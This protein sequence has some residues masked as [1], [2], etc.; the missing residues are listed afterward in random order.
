MDTDRLLPQPAGPATRSVAEPHRRILVLAGVMFAAL[1]AYANTLNADFVWDDRKL[2]VDD[3]AITSWRHI[4][5]IFANDFFFRN[6]DDVPYGYYRPVTTLSYLLDYSIWGLRP[7]GYHLTNILL[8]AA[9]TALVV[10]MLLRLDCGLGASALAALLFAIHPIHTESVAWI[11]GRTD[12]LAF[13]LTAV[14]FLAHPHSASARRSTRGVM[15]LAVSLLAFALALLAKE[16]SVVFVAWIGLLHLIGRRDDPRA[17]ARAALPYAVVLGAYLAWRF[18]I[19]QVGLPGVPPEHH[20]IRAL[21]SAGVTTLRYL[22]WMLWPLDLNAYVQNPYVTGVLDLRFLG[23]IALLVTLALLLRCVQMSARERLLVGMLAA[24]FLPLMNVVRAAG[25]A[26]MGNMMAERFCYFPSFPFLGLVAIGVTALVR[27]SASVSLR[28]ALYLGLAGVVLLGARRTIQ[29]NR[30]WNS[31][32]A[33]LTTTLEQSPNAVLLWGNLAGYHLRKRNLDAAAAA[34]ERGEALDPNSHAVLSSRA[35]WQVVRGHFSD[36][37]PLQERI[38]RE[39]ARGRTAALNNLAYLYRMTGQADLAQAILEQL[40]QAPTN[41]ADPHFNL[42]EIFR[43]RGRL[44]EARSEYQSALANR[45]NDL[46]TAEALAE[47]EVQAG[48]PDDAEAIYRRLI[49]VY[50]NDQR[51]LNNLALVRHGRGDT[52]GALELL[53]RAV[54]AQPSYV[55][56]RLNYAQLLVD[57]GRTADAITQ[58][59]AAAYAGGATELGAQATRQIAA[60]RSPGRESTDYGTNATRAQHRGDVSHVPAAVVL[61]TIDTLRADFVSFNGHAPQTT[62]FLDELARTGVVFSQAYATSSWTVPSM[63]SLFTSLTPSSHGVTRGAVRREKVVSQRALPSSLTTLAETLKQAGYATVGVPGNL[64]LSAEMGFGQGFDYY[65]DAGFHS[66]PTINALANQQLEH[67]FGAG[68]HDTW[69]TRRPFLWVHYFDPH[70]PF[71]ARAPWISRYA[72]AF[73][74]NPSAFPAGLTMRSLRQRFPNPDAAL[75]ARLT[76]LYESEVSYTD[77][78]IRAIGSR[79]GLE[80]PNLLLIV[81]ADHGEEFVDHG[82]LG[83]GHTLYEELVR[84][85]LFLRWPSGLPQ[86]VRVDTPVSLLDIFPT[87][88]ELLD[89]S[90]P[91]MPLQGHS[92]APLLRGAADPTPRRLYFE[93]DRRPRRRAIRDG[94]WKLIREFGDPP[95]MRLFDLDHDP[96]ELHDLAQEHGDIAKRLAGELADWHAALP[97]PPENPRDVPIRN[98][99]ATEQLH[100]LGYLQ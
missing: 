57:A 35:L 48:R 19:I 87:L 17:A 4:P 29:R 38:V 7:F 86:G 2:I 80:D 60:L 47:L 77:D 12:L 62:P 78:A 91:P 92:I 43:A 5:E 3:P 20:L 22:G 11:A 14:A 34:I 81:T 51:I 41:R 90:P 66:A 63:A 88:V 94:T 10:L 36:A 40:V 50:P 82:A 9:G 53:A 71:T 32:L 33:F 74:A 65:A 1:L 83:H 99:A 61:I 46:R 95:R 45:P 68:W 27:H 96:R 31:E 55:K 64:H 56:A 25:P 59:E 18:L 30:D 37:L 84:V 21:L 52:A 54:E 58:L 49:A 23:P 13:T 72:P 73:D 76:P 44:D 26:D 79:L 89:L 39:S 16:M 15:R 6:E 97:R 8:H 98:D 69:K 67:A 93:L 70:D 28:R 100:A 42:A 24:S 75:A 85:P